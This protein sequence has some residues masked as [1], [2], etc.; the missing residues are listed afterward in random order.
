M[1]FPASVKHERRPPYGHSAYASTNVVAEQYDTVGALVGSEL[2]TIQYNPFLVMVVDV[3]PLYL[4]FIP[5]G[6]DLTK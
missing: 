6:N 4:V 1:G 2:I 3:A 5:L